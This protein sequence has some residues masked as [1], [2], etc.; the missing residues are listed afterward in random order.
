[1]GSGVVFSNDAEE[2]VK[3]LRGKIGACRN[4]LAVP[5]LSCAHLAPTRPAAH[6]RLYLRYSM[7]LFLSLSA[8][9]VRSVK[10]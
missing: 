2:C 9:S 7:L 4:D 6:L 8:R 10:A 1:M 5:A 3:W